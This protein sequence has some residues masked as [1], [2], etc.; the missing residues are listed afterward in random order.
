MKVLYSHC[1]CD[2]D[3]G[4]DALTRF[5]LSLFWRRVCTGYGEGGF[6][7]ARPISQ[8]QP[9]LSLWSCGYAIFL[10]LLT[11]F[12]SRHIVKYKEDPEGMP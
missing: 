7:R 12:R 8:S 1:L 2:G 9:R 4:I 10:I 5:S 6:P 11:L 3:P